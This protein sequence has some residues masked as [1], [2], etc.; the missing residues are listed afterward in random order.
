M[1][2]PESM[3]NGPASCPPNFSRLGRLPPLA[4]LGYRRKLVPELRENFLFSELGWY[5]EPFRPC[6]VEWFFYLAK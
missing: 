6:R 5:R 3:S 1:T 2:G 4:G